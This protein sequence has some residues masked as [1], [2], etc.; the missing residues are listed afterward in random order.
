MGIR[1]IF[2]LPLLVNGLNGFSGWGLNSG[3]CEML[4][5]L[6]GDSNTCVELA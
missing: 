2:E 1:G 3:L 4:D 6:V 5:V